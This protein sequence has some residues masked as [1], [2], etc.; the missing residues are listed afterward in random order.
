MKLSADKLFSVGQD[1]LQAVQEFLKD[2]FMAVELE[3][4]V[5]DAYI[6]CRKVAALIKG[7][8]FT[9]GADGSLVITGKLVSRGMSAHKLDGK[10]DTLYVW[11]KCVPVYLPGGS[12]AKVILTKV[13][14][15]DNETHTDEKVV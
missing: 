3:G 10:W 9:I 12:I 7:G 13:T 5:N 6:R 8:G 4:D 2:G 11:Y 1:K 14:E 15:K